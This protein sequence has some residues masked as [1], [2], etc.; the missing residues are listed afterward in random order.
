MVNPGVAYKDPIAEKIAYE[1]YI[2][3]YFERRANG[4]RG[5]RIGQCI[6]GARL[7]LGITSSIISGYARNVPTNSTVPKIGAIVKT[8]ESQA[9]HVAVVIKISGDSIEIFES[10]GS[11]GYELA[12]TRWLKINNPLIVGYLILEGGE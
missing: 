10:N 4:F 11:A 8:A 5:Q 7:F 12:G 6:T 1:A 3:D 2:S 9:G